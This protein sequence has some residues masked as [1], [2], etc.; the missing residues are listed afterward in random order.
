MEE[1]APTTQN[2]THYAKLL[3][4]HTLVCPAHHTSLTHAR[5]HTHT[6]A[7][8]HA[9]TRTHTHTHVRARTHTLTLTLLPRSMHCLM[10][11]AS[12]AAHVSSASHPH[13]DN[14]RRAHQKRVVL[15]PRCRCWHLCLVLLLLSHDSQEAHAR[16]PQAE[17]R[18]DDGTPHT[19][20]AE[21]RQQR[22]ARVHNQPRVATILTVRG[23][24]PPWVR[25]EDQARS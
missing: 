5:A 11:G 8:T 7:R 25:A 17:A 24:A 22:Q 1:C 18:A 9:H 10:R 6:H 23:S 15:G 14:R 20:P 19:R 13:V 3:I 21:T 16:L 2:V 4:Q 12:H